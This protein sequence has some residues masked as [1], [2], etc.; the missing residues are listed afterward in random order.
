MR[1]LH[2]INS[3]SVGGAQKLLVDLLPMLKENH[4]DA[5]LLVLFSSNTEY[6]HILKK[7]GVRVYSCEVA[8]L[9]NLK[10]I[11]KLLS[12]RNSFDIFHFHLFPSL[13][14]GALFS[15]FTNKKI[16]YTEHNTHNRRRNIS[17]IRLLEKIVYSRYNSIIS[18]TNETQNNL[19]NWLNLKDGFTKFNVVK[20]GVNL[21]LF[22]PVNVKPSF[23]ILMV[24]R[25]SIA[26]DQD[27]LIRA[28][29][30]LSIDYP[31][32]SLWFVGDGER[33]NDCVNLVKQLNIESKVKFL[34]ER[35][36]VQ[37][38]IQNCFCGVQSSHWEGFGLTAVEFMGCGKPI[39]ASNV[40]G[41]S[42]IVAD[43][44]LLF[45]TGDAESLAN[46]IKKLLD[47]SRFYNDISARCFNRAQNYDI[48]FMVNGY[49]NLYES[50]Y[51]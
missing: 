36:D 42:Q 10:V 15:L 41:L 32:L 20:N 2:I 3:M 5:S 18:I 8:N 45:P 38:L 29:S 35:L 47:D 7:E 16:I 31:Q 19:L 13:Y 50:I 28:F 46:Q 25:F 4:V 43:A 14:W 37:N 51:G 23:N 26:K 27:T 48:K 22:S 6:C 34:G 44:G 30:L 24:S 9:Y 21:K 33:L 12:F 11:F 49:L 1:V 17:A 40:D 39:I